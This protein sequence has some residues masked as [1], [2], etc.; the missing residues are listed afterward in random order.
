MLD[1]GLLPKMS[2]LFYQSDQKHWD[3]LSVRPESSKLVR[4]IYSFSFDRSQLSLRD[5]RIY[6]TPDPAFLRP[7]YD[8][9]PL[10]GLRDISQNPFDKMSE[11]GAIESTIDTNDPYCLMQ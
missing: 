2:V 8:Q 11:T 9:S 1:A 5:C 3:N 4:S 10:R 6:P 7:G